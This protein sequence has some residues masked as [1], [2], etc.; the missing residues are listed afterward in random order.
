MMNFIYDNMYLLASVCAGLCALFATF[1]I[2]EFSS[3]TSAR[4]KERFLAE[5]AV[6]L[7]DVLLQM[8]ANRILDLS[9]A[10]AAVSFIL[11]GGLSSFLSDEVNWIRTVAIGTISAVV[12]FLT[13][14][15]ISGR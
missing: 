7:D 3:Y 6:E 1:V 9:I 4:Y 2:V 14:G 15:S 10:I 8:P 12:A 5:A 13:P 11:F